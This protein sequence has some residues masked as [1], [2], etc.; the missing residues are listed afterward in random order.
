MSVEILRKKK[1]RTFLSK[2]RG[3]Y[4]RLARFNRRWAERIRKLK[5]TSS[6]S[7]RGDR[8]VCVAISIPITHSFG[9]FP[10]SKLS[11]GAWP[12]C[13]D[14]ARTFRLSSNTPGARYCWCLHADNNNSYDITYFISFPGRIGKVLPSLLLS[15]HTKEGSL[16]FDV[17]KTTKLRTRGNR[18]M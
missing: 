12:I 14:T 9:N 2:L 1:L 16:H 18:G 8:F 3:K 17:G 6:L 13:S 10:L 5:Y 15:H 7:L 11:R 4:Q